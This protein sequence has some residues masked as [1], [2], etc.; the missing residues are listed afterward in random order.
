MSLRDLVNVTV[1]PSRAI[2]MH[3]VL[4]IDFDNFPPCLKFLRCAQCWYY[5]VSMEEKWE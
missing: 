2:V 4:K 5:T 1:S 3:F